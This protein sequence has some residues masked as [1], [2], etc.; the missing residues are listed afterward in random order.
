MDKK[1]YLAEVCRLA[2][3]VGHDIFLCNVGQMMYAEAPDIP[4]GR[5]L[6]ISLQRLH[7]LRRSVFK[8][9]IARAGRHEHLIVNTHATFR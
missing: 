8:D 4:P 3:G 7:S 5:I 6:D 9:I 1:P 2:K